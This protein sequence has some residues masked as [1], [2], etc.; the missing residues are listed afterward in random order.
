VTQTAEDEVRRENRALTVMHEMTAALMQSLDS[1]ELLQRVVDR[2]TELLDTT[3]G[4]IGLLDSDSKQIVIRHTTG[5]IEPT[6]GIRIARAQGIAGR[7]WDSCAP[8]VFNDLREWDG[9]V[10]TGLHGYRRVAEVPLRFDQRFLGVLGVAATE[11]RPNFNAADVETLERFA[12]VVS[13][14][15]RNAE[16]FEAERATRN[17][18]ERLLEA[19][20]A[21]TSSLELPHVLRTILQQLQR[22]IPYDSATVQ[23][24]RGNRAVI[25]A[26]VGFPKPAQLIGLSFDLTNPDIPNGL[27]VHRH[28]PLILGD[29]RAFSAFTEAPTATHIRGWMGVPLLHGDDVVGII[30]LDKREPD[31]YTSEHA[32]VAIAFAAQAAIAIQNA[33]LYADANDQLAQRAAVEKRL[34]AAQIEYRTLVEQLPATVIYRYSIPEQKTLYISPQLESLLGYTPDEW[35]ADRDLWWKVIHPEDREPTKQLLAIKDETGEDINIAHRLIARD[36]RILWFQNRSRTITD[37]GRPWETHGVMLDVSD[38]KRAEQELRYANYNLA[39]LNRIAVAL[40]N[41][42]DINHALDAVSREVTELLG[43]SSCKVTLGPCSTD[44]P[45]VP[46]IVRGETIGSISVDSDRNEAIDLR[47]LETIAGQVANAIE[48]ARLFEEESQSRELAERLQESAE[49][50]NESLELEVVLPSILD[51]IARVIDYDSASVQLVEG[52]SMR[53]IAVRGLPEAEIGR[54]RDLAS[55]DYNRRLATNPAPFIY[56]VV[57]GDTSWPGDTHDL[58]A[59]RSNIGIPLVVRDRIIGALTLDSRGVHAYDD[60]DLNIASAFGRQA[61]IAIENA[62]LYTSAQHAREAADAANQAKSAFLA[63][64]SHELRTPL[65]AII[66]FSS[67]LES[68]VG[69]KLTDR[70]QRFLRNINSSGEYLLGI[71]NDILDLSKIEAGKMTLDAEDVSVPEM[72]EGI[73]RVLRGVTLPRRIQLVVDISEDVSVVE[74]DPIKLKQILYNL[75]ANAVKFSPDAAA[76]RIAARS[77]KSDESPIHRD[78][79]QVSVADE[80]IGIDPKDHEMIFEE[81]RQV[82]G[83]TKRP[84]GTGLGLTL[85]KRFLQMHGGTISVQSTPGRGSDFTFVLPVK[86]GSMLELNR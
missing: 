40:T 33:R 75:I 11:E 68:S 29:V 65:N 54:V 25:V 85:V 79:I 78:A 42:V 57:L 52:D 19:A 84:Q 53:V 32:R 27:I 64:M 28:E 55:H 81:F 60:R 71:I 73:C 46:L 8:I 12:A 44:T 17:H 34:H 7:V 61:A 4:F 70:Q 3:Y 77:L 26:G 15:I 41:V 31:F 66:G 30:T 14:A 13:V 49:I 86:L 38:V 22:V 48:N 82:Q 20:K 37:G 39:A 83:T 35:I 1:A 76:I 36:G 67:V 21:V 2:A 56:N 62:R 16:L 6:V 58:G 47:L 59:V 23:E 10:L 74:A 63:T 80:G 43:A 72:I 18:A 9:H 5:G 24:L 45:C 69:E 51:G 50:V